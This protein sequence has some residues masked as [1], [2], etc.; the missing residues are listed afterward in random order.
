MMNKTP[1]AYQL[2][3]NIIEDLSDK[4]LSELNK[5]L[6]DYKEKYQRTYRSLRQQPFIND[7]FGL[8]L[9][10]VEYRNQMEEETEELA[11]WQKNLRKDWLANG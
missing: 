1:L 9:D 4:Q 11:D 3:E 7:L 6:L 5:D 10:Q 2:F 8:I